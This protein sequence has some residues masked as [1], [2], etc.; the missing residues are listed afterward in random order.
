[1]SLRR[2]PR[3]QVALDSH[4]PVLI[5]YDELYAPETFE[6]AAWHASR[7][8]AIAMVEGALA[9][10]GATSVLLV[11][12]NLYYRSMRHTF[13]KLARKC[14]IALLLCV[15]SFAIIFVECGLSLCL[16]DQV[17]FVC[18]HLQADLDTALARNSQRTGTACVSE[19]TMRAMHARFESPEV[20]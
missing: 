12:D 4:H 2:P 8:Q 19:A 9:Q 11:D 5:S 6:P 17:G 10:G 16:L 20:R 18:I 14:M 13:L 15:A 3:V 7:R 1:M